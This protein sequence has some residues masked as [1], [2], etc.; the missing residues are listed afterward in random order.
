MSTSSYAALPPQWRAALRQMHDDYLFRCVLCVFCVRVLRVRGLWGARR[1]AEGTASERTRIVV[2]MVLG[3]GRRNAGMRDCSQSQTLYRP[4]F[5]SAYGTLAF[6]SA[7]N[8]C[9]SS[10]SCS[11][12]MV[13][14]VA[15]TL[16]PSPQ[17]PGGRVARLR[18]RQAAG[19]AGRLRHDGVRRGPGLRAR[20]RAAS[21]EGTEAHGAPGHP[22]GLP[23]CRSRGWACWA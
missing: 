12:R 7:C 14:A 13:S 22:H 19:A 3:N 4:C 23:A 17:A 6:Q 1:G 10:Y 21:H 8:R 16:A 9:V 20:V 2:L 15:H 5:I 18:P 11:P